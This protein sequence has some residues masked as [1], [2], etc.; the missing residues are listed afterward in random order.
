MRPSFSLSQ[1]KRNKQIVVRLPKFFGC[2]GVRF[3]RM[4]QNYKYE[5]R[6]LSDIVQHIIPHFDKYPLQ[7]SKANDYKAFRQICF[8]MKQNRH[9]QKAGLIQIIKLAG[10]MNEAGKRKY[11][12]AHLLQVIDKMKV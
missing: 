12:P 3:S 5:V 7:T 1:H 2:G 8:L 10:I 9:V 4:D 11:S 6:N